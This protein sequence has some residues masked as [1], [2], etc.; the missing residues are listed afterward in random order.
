MKAA[1]QPLLFWVGV[2]AIVGVLVTWQ[3]TSAP[4]SEPSPGQID[5]PQLLNVAERKEVID[6]LETIVETDGARAAMT[7]LRQQ[8][9][10]DGRVLSSCHPLVH[11]VGQAAYAHYQD[12]ATAMQFR[13]EFCNSGYVHGVIEARFSEGINQTE[14]LALCKDETGLRGW[15]CWHG[16]GHGLMYENENDLPD[17]LISCDS[18]PTLAA[19]N[20]CQNGVF[21][22]NFNSNDTAHPSIYRSAAEPLYPCADQLE[23]HQGN[24]YLYAPSY[25]LAVHPGAYSQ[26]L[27][28]C[29]TA[30]TEWQSACTTGVGAELAKQNL[31]RLGSVIR[32]CESGL[33]RQASECTSGFINYLYLHAGGNADV[34]NPFCAQ[35]P[36]PSRQLCYDRMSQVDQF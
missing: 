34:G 18:L 10:A 7:S 11:A 12:F 32:W 29:R 33:G 4:Q 2:T 20:A 8:A 16:I 23:R 31:D 35:L 19:Q 5:A 6:G 15:E 22:E 25:F 3:L 26:T 30:P 9:E 21:M 17:A 36:A 24:C 28:I 13:D 27:S 1:Q 14:L